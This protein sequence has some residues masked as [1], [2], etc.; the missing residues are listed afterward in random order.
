[1]RREEESLQPALSLN[2]GTPL[3]CLPVPGTPAVESKRRNQKKPRGC[4]VDSAES[5]IG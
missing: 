1:M 5:A 2:A 4:V 3:Q